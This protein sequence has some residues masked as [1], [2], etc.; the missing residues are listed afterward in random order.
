[1]V[2]ETKNRVLRSLPAQTCAA[3]LD[4]CERGHFEGKTELG[5]VGEPAK[6]VYFPETS[7]ISALATYLDGSTIEMANIGCEACTGIAL[8][9][10]H[11][12]LLVTTEVQI[13][14]TALSVSADEF[15][16]LMSSL[17][18]F[19]SALLSSTQA[20]FYQIMVSG[21]CNGAHSAKQRLARWLLTMNDRADV[22]IMHLTQEYLAEMLGLRRATIS[23]AASAFQ[24]AGL[25]HYTRGQISIT[26]RP[27]LSRASCECYGMVREA[28]DSLLPEASTPH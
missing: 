3:V 16:N 19:Q 4:A 14:G 26:D 13:S 25:I 10:G 17:P 24:E 1:M 12:D 21:A 18:T 22:E 23:N 15:V 8:V 28:Y 27:G 2:H 6:K 9:L 20:L 7:V 11:S 5:R